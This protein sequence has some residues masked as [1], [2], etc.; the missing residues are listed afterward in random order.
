MEN[1]GFL[2]F[3]GNFRWFLTYGDLENGLIIASTS[4]SRD[5]GLLISHIITL[6]N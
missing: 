2:E 3:S 4:H 5:H 6:F 1:D